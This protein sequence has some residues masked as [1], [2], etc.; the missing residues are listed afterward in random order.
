MHWT[1]ALALALSLL[2]ASAAGEWTD[3]R[4]HIGT[5]GSAWTILILNC[6]QRFRLFVAWLV[7]GFQ[8]GIAA[9]AIAVGSGVVYWEGA[10]AGY[11]VQLFFDNPNLLGASLATAS[12]ATLVLTRSAIS[13]PLWGLGVMGI[14]MTGSR[15]S[16]VGAAVGLLVWLA[17]TSQSIKRLLILG[18]VS[19]LVGGLL[20]LG[21]TQAASQKSAVNLLALSSDF[22]KSDWITS[23]AQ[24]VRVER[25]ATPG[26]VAG[27]EAH[28]IKGESG[29]LS[30]LVIYQWVSRSE[31]GVPYVASIYLRAD[32]PQ[33]LVLSTQLSS[34]VCDVGTDWSR[35][36]TPAGY[37]DG[38]AALQLRLETIT[39]PGRFE[40]YAWGAQ[41]E[42]GIVASPLEERRKTV[43]SSSLLARLDASTWFEQSVSPIGRVQA[44]RLAFEDFRAAP[45]SG[46]GLGLDNFPDR[47][48]LRW[49]E[50]DVVDH[51]HNGPLFLLASM[52]VLG[53]ISWLMV[54]GASMSRLGRSGRVRSAPIIATVLVL[55]MLD[56]SFFSSG[57]FYPFWVVL[58]FAVVTASNSEV[59]EAKMKPPLKFG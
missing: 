57:V 35:C 49:S 44:W 12:V 42:I 15:L 26:P 30:S 52:G 17:V 37:G 3:W 53:L 4:W 33:Q 24:T 11:R 1:F 54:L 28:R 29:T 59:R 45:L 25:Q 31:A 51:P 20:V 48:Q 14:V 38:Y 22:H 23:H 2:A 18:C 7:P 40:V 43:F 19:M 21:A 56:L 50:A 47:Y 39:R 16:L 8:L 9:V 46:L 34:A 58:G 13:V 55:N 41:L 27:S 36:V 6:E 32:V 5:L 10:L